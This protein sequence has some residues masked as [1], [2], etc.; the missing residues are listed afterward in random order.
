M[1]FSTFLVNKYNHI[2]G[3]YRSILNHCDVIGQ[4]SNRI[5]RK[6]AKYGLLRRSRSFNVIEVGIN[7]KPVCDFLLVINDILS[8]IVSELSQLS[9]QFFWHFA[10]WAS[11]WGGGLETTYDVHFGLTGK[12]VVDFLLVLTELFSLGVIR[13]RRYTSENRSKIGDFAPT[14]SLWPKI[15]G[16]RWRPHQ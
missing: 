12:R 14:R 15:S 6:N 7:R 2:Y 8:R 4:R 3:H 5:R 9:V 11:L 16:R 10:L 1:C 13:L